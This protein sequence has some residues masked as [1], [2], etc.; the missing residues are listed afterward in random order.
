[1]KTRVFILSLLLTLL[2]I[3]LF[4]E[5]VEGDKVL[6]FPLSF[7]VFYDYEQWYNSPLSVLNPLN[8]VNISF[9]AL[10]FLINSLIYYFII[11]LGVKVYKKIKN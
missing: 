4:S 9:N 6:G 7:Y 8:L 5:K 1:M 10:A 3:F 2:T 11:L